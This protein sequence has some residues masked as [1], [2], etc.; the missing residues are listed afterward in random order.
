MTD[1]R[2]HPQPRS[3][4]DPRGYLILTA[5]LILLGV[6]LYLGIHQISDEPALAS[7]PGGA[8]L[9]VPQELPDLTLQTLDGRSVSLRDLQGKALVVNFWATWCPPCRMEMP[10]LQA[11][12][13][14]HL[15]EDVVV[16]AINAGEAVSLVQPFVDENNLTFDVL[17]DPDMRAMTAFRVASLPTSFFVDRQGLIR[18]RHGGALTLAEIESSMAPLR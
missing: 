14:A 3:G 17:L 4:R 9:V 5:G 10:D 13:Q 15:D 18:E 6:G 11:F 8:V 16:V 1:R 12:Y 7:V 2:R